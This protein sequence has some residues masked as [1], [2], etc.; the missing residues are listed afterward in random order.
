MGFFRCV[1]VPCFAASLLHGQQTAD[2]SAGQKLFQKSCTACHGENGKG[3]R[4][5]DLTTGQ[6]RWGGSNAAIVQNILSGIPDTQ[7]PAFPMPPADAELIVA[8][9]RSLNSN[10]PEEE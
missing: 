6:W 10:A 4:A 1:I 7:M 5:P 3:G 2:V 9:L 8:Y